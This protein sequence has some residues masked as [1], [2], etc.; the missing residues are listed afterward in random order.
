M[1]QT[2]KIVRN[3]QLVYPASDSDYEIL[4]SYG[5]PMHNMTADFLPTLLT[6]L[7]SKVKRT[8]VRFDE[9]EASMLER[10]KEKWKHEVSLTVKS[11]TLTYPR[12]TQEALVEKAIVSLRRWYRGHFYLLSSEEKRAGKSVKTVL[13]KTLTPRKEV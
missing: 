12:D 10:F 8:V 5:V 13:T 2:L 4:L 1:K 9:L 7:P 11:V 6:Y 3:G